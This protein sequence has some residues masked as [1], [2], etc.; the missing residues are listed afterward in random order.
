MDIVFIDQFMSENPQFPD[1]PEDSILWASIKLGL[2]NNGL[3]LSDIEAQTL[4]HWHCNS[5]SFYCLCKARGFIQFHYATW[6]E[7]LY[8]AKLV[9]DKGRLSDKLKIARFFG[10]DDEFKE[11]KYF[12]NYSDCM[13]AKDLDPEK[14]YNIKV[15]N[16][17]SD[18]DHFMAGYVFNGLLYLSDSGKRGIH[19][20]AK[21]VIPKKKFQWILEV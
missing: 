8:L 15:E 17:A 7:K 4:A 14:G 2:E 10:F 6:V 1:K 21:D 19:V 9:T 20:P 16:N 13:S 5:E 18:G 11:L 3:K 12:Y